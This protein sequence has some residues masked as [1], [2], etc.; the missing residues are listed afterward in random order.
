MRL[1][2]T[3]RLRLR[4]ATDVQRPGAREPTVGVDAE[5]RHAP[6]QLARVRECGLRHDEGPG[7]RKPRR[8]GQEAVAGATRADLRLEQRLPEPVAPPHVH[9]RA[10][11]VDREQRRTARRPKQHRRA[12]EALVTGELRV[13]VGLHDRAKDTQRGI[14]REHAFGQR[15]LLDA[16]CPPRETVA[17]AVA[18]QIVPDEASQETPPQPQMLPPFAG[19]GTTSRTWTIRL[20][21]VSTETSRPFQL[22]PAASGLSQC[23]ATG[24]STDRPTR[25]S[26]PQTYSTDVRVT[27]VTGQPGIG[28]PVATSSAKSLPFPPIT[29]MTTPV[30]RDHGGR[31]D[32]R[33]PATDLRH[34]RAERAL[35]DGCAGSRIES[36]HRIPARDDEEQRPDPSRAGACEVERLTDDHAVELPNPVGVQLLRTRRVEA[37]GDAVRDVRCPAV[38]RPIDRRGRGLAPARADGGGENDGGDEGAD[39]RPTREPGA[40]NR[41][42]TGGECAAGSGL[43]S[44]ASV[45]N[46]R[47]RRAVVR[48]PAGAQR[49]R[50]P[51]ARIAELDRATV[52][53]DEPPR[54]R[55][56]EAGSAGA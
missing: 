8:L 26:P 16:G 5:A 2:D 46:I 7:R 15:L 49:R 43:S 44:R 30:A 4:A 18:A 14:E 35:P 50:A 1:P 38:R 17:F 52:D 24:T 53:L 23:E 42:I 55:E 34:R 19:P 10:L 31:R 27:T 45:A 25:R 48:R 11:R 21:I 20:A 37:G 12:T 54:D 6:T 32:T 36:E 3:E 47:A 33:R 40:T 13:V 22:T 9:E 41:C 51:S 29:Y 39:E 56:P 28:L